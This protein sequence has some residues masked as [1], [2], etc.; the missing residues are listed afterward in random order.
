VTRHMINWMNEMKWILSSYNQSYNQSVFFATIL[1][2]LHTHTH[3]RQS[4]L[5]NNNHSSRSFITHFFINHQKY[6]VRVEVEKNE[7]IDFTDESI[8]NEHYYYFFLYCSS[9]DEKL[10]RTSQQ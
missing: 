1:N 7:V 2:I 4:T 6:W 3:N 8:S 10:W 5:I 9:K